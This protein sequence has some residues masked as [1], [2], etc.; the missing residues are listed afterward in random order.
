MGINPASEGRSENRL[1]SPTPESLMPLV[2][3][4]KQPPLNATLGSEL[5]NMSLQGSPKLSPLLWLLFRGPWSSSTLVPGGS[6]AFL[7][8]MNWSHRAMEEQ[9]TSVIEESEFD[10]FDAVETKTKS[11]D[12]DPVMVFVEIEKPILKSQGT[13]NNQNNLKKRI[14][15]KNSHFLISKLTTKSVIKTVW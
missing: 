6:L 2:S 15:L 13:L 12:F 1:Q 4:Q 5:P 3:P 9:I 14:K 10:V 7:L 8:E 11:L